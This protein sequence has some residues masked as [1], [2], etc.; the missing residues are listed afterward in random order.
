MPANTNTKSRLL[1]ARDFA[2]S[3][4][5]RVLVAQSVADITLLASEDKATRHELGRAIDTLQCAY[6]ETEKALS[7]LDGL[8]ID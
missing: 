7:I 8:I 2:A 4:A 6:D 5:N 3:A 1:E